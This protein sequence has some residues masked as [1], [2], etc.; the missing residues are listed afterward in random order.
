MSRHSITRIG[1]TRRVAAAVGFSA[2]VLTVGAPGI[3]SAD[4]STSG[5]SGQASSTGQRDSSTSTSGSSGESST[6][7][8]GSAATSSPDSVS[9][10]ADSATSSIT[11]PSEVATGAADADTATGE[12]DPAPIDP[13]AADPT[14]IDP[15]PVDQGAGSPVG[16]GFE[17]SAPAVAP[18][19]PY[20]RH[21][22]PEPSPAQSTYP[23]SPQPGS[24]AVENDA[25]A[26]ASN[27]GTSPH[28]AAA[29][30]AP[31][32][33]EPP[34]VVTEWRTDS[35]IESLASISGQEAELTEVDPRATIDD[36]ALP[37]ATETALALGAVGV[38]AVASRRT[39]SF[40]MTPEEIEQYYAELQI[41]AAQEQAADPDNRFWN[42]G[43]AD[44][45]SG[46]T[47]SAPPAGLTYSV[48][49]D[50]SGVF[51][52][53][54]NSGVDIAVT[55]IYVPTYSSQ[56]LVVIKAG[57]S[58]TMPHPTE[59]TPLGFT[60][61]VVQTPRSDGAPTVVGRILV[62]PSTQLGDALIV[63]SA[64][65]SMSDYI[66]L[67]SSTTPD[68][69]GEDPADQF[70]DAG[71]GTTTPGTITYADPITA[72]VSYAVVDGKTVRIFNDG[73]TSI[74]VT[75]ATMGFQTLTFDV[76]APGESG[77]YTSVPGSWQMVTVQAPKASEGSMVML[78]YIVRLA[79]GPT[80]TSPG[81]G[82]SAIPLRD[83]PPV[84][85]QAPTGKLVEVSRS[86]DGR[87]VTYRA[88]ATDPDGDPITYSVILQPSRGS[89]TQQ[90][91]NTFTYTVTDRYYL[92]YGQV[93]DLFVVGASD[94]KGDPT[95]L[96]ARVDIEFTQVNNAPQVEVT[97]AEH[98][99]GAIGYHTYLVNVTDPDWGQYSEW[100]GFDQVRYS[101]TTPSFGAIDIVRSE[102]GPVEVRY[103][104]D[105]IRAHQ[106]AYDTSFDIIV[107]DGQ[108]GG[109]VTIPF[110]IH[111]PF[112][113][114][115]PVVTI[116]A[117]PGSN[118]EFVTDAEL[119]LILTD[120]DFDDVSVVSLTTSHGGTAVLRDGMIVYTPTGSVT[121]GGVKYYA[122][123]EQIT[124][125]VDDGHGGQATRLQNIYVRN[126]AGLGWLDPGQERTLI[127][128]DNTKWANNSA[129]LL[130][131]D[132]SLR[133]RDYQQHIADLEAHFDP[134]LDG[135]NTTLQRQLV[136]DYA[137]NVIS[138]ALV[139]VSRSIAQIQSVVQRID[140]QLAKS[141]FSNI[142]VSTQVAL[143]FLNNFQRDMFGIITEVDHT[144]VT[145][146]TQKA[147]DYE[148]E[149]PAS[150]TPISTYGLFDTLTANTNKDKPFYVQYVRS[151]IDNADR[152]IVY[153]AGTDVALDATQSVVENVRAAN[154]RPDRDLTAA[155]YDAYIY[156][157]SGITPT[158]ILLV[159]YSQGGIDAINFANSTSLPVVGVV[160]FGTPLMTADSVEI[161]AVHIRDSRDD[162]VH[163]GRASYGELTQNY[164][165][166][167]FVGTAKDVKDNFFI[168]FDVHMNWDTY[169][170]LGKQFDAVVTK[171]AKYISI[172][173]VLRDFDGKVGPDRHYGLSQ[174]SVTWL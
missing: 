18:D 71:D 158:E 25:P 97:E 13:A 102:S 125:V 37:S 152:M 108:D 10:T 145:P 64:T 80:S 159:G 107:D 160:T 85:N 16:S 29:E 147:D 54:N 131:R 86:A 119:G 117:F 98:Q 155:I 22:L 44:W 45:G 11:V 41:L 132:T 17:L 50:G 15:A 82:I 49:D 143:E 20:G 163:L 93:T 127:F 161:P 70:V 150:A 55:N 148:I 2:A 27:P 4:D 56:G 46:A 61:Y 59:A 21:A 137:M 118:G 104:P 138:D 144:K 32:D 151:D 26:S 112:Y 7:T 103:S 77:T 38:G 88:E 157:P 14:P 31:A 74:A 1:T 100:I 140:A 63:S 52:L 33:A 69:A 58:Y 66:P 96:S 90:G 166:N 67:H 79:A 154:R 167:V 153:V 142:R 164:V 8:P 84:T 172:A 60:A 65:E 89:V 51:T 156:S 57:E 101:S 106:S 23:A 42:Y 121:I 135:Y 92:H 5:S 75:R 94:G 129:Y 116:V 87:S 12:V 170:A 120:D 173:L 134:E 36:T 165:G 115:N 169:K 47:G 171:Q 9:G 40:D 114:Q 78:G 123:T 133:D 99:L 122:Y 105:L 136:R 109:K 168:P 76:L 24:S 35:E 83:A 73:T 113:N 34:I 39:L 81:D 162:V 48:P 6:S 139:M 149:S 126:T 53:H 111:V 141:G 68:Y 30:S 130:K 128:T 62:A 28:A 174:G 3:A 124:V 91:D 110:T 19:G 95:G 72:G 43:D 146:P